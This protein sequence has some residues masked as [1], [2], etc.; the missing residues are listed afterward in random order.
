M[1]LRIAQQAEAR[2]GGWWEWSVWIEAP[3]ADL[4]QLARVVYVLHPT[5]ANPVRTVTDRHSAFRLNESGWGEFRLYATAVFTDGHSEHL[6]HDLALQSVDGGRAPTKEAASLDVPA[7]RVP[8]PSPPQTPRW[9]L[10]L[11]AGLVGLAVVATYLLAASWPDGSGRITLFGGVWV[12]LAGREVRLLLVALFAGALGG[13]AHAV[14]I[15]TN[16]IGSRRYLVASWLPWFV[17]QPLTGAMLAVVVYLALRRGL[18]S[19]SAPASDV[20]AVGVA[21]L[22]AL[23]GLFSDQATKRLRGMFETMFQPPNR[24]KPRD[25]GA[26]RGERPEDAAAIPPR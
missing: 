21:V 19:P 20:R 15:L 12:I 7:L 3:P 5:F 4:D 25:S 24:V 2:E 13:A 16:L 17:L 11:G 1:A 6:E 9:M 22:G 10:R 18:L 26:A 8:G 14:S 23:A